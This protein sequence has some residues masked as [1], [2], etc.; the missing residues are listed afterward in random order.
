MHA[1]GRRSCGQCAQPCRSGSNLGPQTPS[2]SQLLQ[3]PCTCAAAVLLAPTQILLRRRVRAQGPGQAARPLTCLTTCVAAESA[4]V[5]TSADVLSACIVGLPGCHGGPRLRKTSSGNPLLTWLDTDRGPCHSS[6]SS[7][8]GSPCYVTQVGCIVV[9]PCKAGDRM[10]G[11]G[12]H[13]RAV[14]GHPGVRA[15]CPGLLRLIHIRWAVVGAVTPR[16]LCNA[17]ELLRCSPSYL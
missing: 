11:P 16:R 7:D 6:A 9:R 2:A 10:V 4:C 5:H 3:P 8:E 17:R 12:E 13:L 1:V 14:P 15:S